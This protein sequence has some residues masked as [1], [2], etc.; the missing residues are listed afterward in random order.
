MLLFFLRGEGLTFEDGRTSVKSIVGSRTYLS[1]IVDH[2][3]E[4]EGLKAE[5]DEE[6]RR[7]RWETFEALDNLN[8][9]SRRRRWFRNSQEDVSESLPQ[10]SAAKI[11]PPMA[12]KYTKDNGNPI[13][14]KS[15]LNICDG[16]IL[17]VQVMRKPMPLTNPQDKFR[18]RIAFML[19]TLTS[20]NAGYG[21]LLQQHQET[22]SIMPPKAPLLKSVSLS[23][24]Q[25]FS[26]SASIQQ[27]EMTDTRANV[28]VVKDND[29]KMHHVISVKQSLREDLAEHFISP[30]VGFPI[31][32]VCHLLIFYCGL[33]PS[34]FMWW[35]P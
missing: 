17:P 21:S 24:E 23:S 4:R 32:H 28:T 12:E 35:M 15:E 11:K 16:W 29:L 30:V 20:V 7:E 27:G 33:N 31:G 14:W 18:A 3:D 9:T 10:I 19:G 5:Y 2:E 8:K 22:I 13:S 34:S 25:V 6:Q 1:L 26:V